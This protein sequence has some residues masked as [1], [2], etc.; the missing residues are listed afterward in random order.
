MIYN[1]KF[2]KEYNAFSIKPDVC[3]DNTL[4]FSLNFNNTSKKYS[5][6]YPSSC[7][8]SKFYIFWNNRW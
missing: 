8:I 3:L 4:F 2:L 6:V 7:E 1:S 5:T